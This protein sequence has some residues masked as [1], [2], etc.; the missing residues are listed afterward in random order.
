M[1]A[2]PCPRCGGPLVSSTV[3]TAIWQGERLSVVEDIPALVCSSCREQYY[4]DD[5]TDALRTLN[6]EG[7]P[8]ESA[9]KTIQ[10]SVFSLEERIRVRK[11]LE[12]DTYVD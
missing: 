8:E 9:D 4:D 12:E 1:S 10:V 11:P 5:V 6:E 2:A 7:F 3:K